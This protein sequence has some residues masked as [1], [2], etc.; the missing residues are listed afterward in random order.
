MSPVSEGDSPDVLMDSNTTLN[1]LVEALAGT[2]ASVVTAR[3]E[4]EENGTGIL[5][6]GIVQQPEEVEENLLG[7]ASREDEE[8]GMPENAPSVEAVRNAVRRVL[9]PLV[10]SEAAVQFPRFYNQRQRTNPGVEDFITPRASPSVFFADTRVEEDSANTVPTEHPLIARSHTGAVHRRNEEEPEPICFDMDRAVECDTITNWV[11]ENLPSG[12]SEDS[13]SESTDPVD[14]EMTEEERNGVDE[15]LGRASSDLAAITEAALRYGMTEIEFLELTG[16]DPTVLGELPEEMHADI[17]RQEVSNARP[18]LVPVADDAAALIASLTSSSLRNDIMLSAPEDVVRTLPPD[19]HAEAILARQRRQA[20]RQANRPSRSPA[21]PLAPRPT[22]TSVPSTGF[23]QLMGQLDWLTNNVEG[24]MNRGNP[25]RDRARNQDGFLI[26]DPTFPSLPISR[27]VGSAPKISATTVE[28]VCAHYT[29]S[30]AQPPIPVESLDRIIALLWSLKSNTAVENL[31]F[32]LALYGQ[33]RRMI[34][35]ILIQ[36]LEELIDLNVKDSEAIRLCEA[37]RG[38]IPLSATRVAFS[39]SIS[40]V[41][42][43]LIIH[44]PASLDDV[45]E[46]G[47][48]DRLVNLCPRDLSEETLEIVLRILHVLLVPEKNVPPTTRRHRQ[49]GH[50][51]SKVD[52]LQEILT[53]DSVRL[54]TSIALERKA[55]GMEIIQ[56]LC[57]TR[58]HHLTVSQS[59]FGS[60]V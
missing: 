26:I 23:A 8:R 55:Q 42:L 21:L 29:D 14:M 46:Y 49:K 52:R 7:E 13:D 6:V 19:L 36:R 31:L 32:N 22:L 44:I 47:F 12:A 39:S 24:I 25:R 41:L 17:I 33:A 45:A 43:F 38:Q 48:L 2:G 10:A 1:R 16:I 5:S 28:A 3:V 57:E 9:S 53:P 34:L 35:S 58:V 4:A 37:H 60:L 18:G 11:M 20:R 59:L 30:E 56:A 54:I 51:G 27:P 50:S 15:E 40:S